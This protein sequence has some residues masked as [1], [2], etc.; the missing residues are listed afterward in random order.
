MK[1]KKHTVLLTKISCL[2]TIIIATVLL[3]IFYGLSWQGIDRI[4]GTITD[5]DTSS[6]ED[7]DDF[8]QKKDNHAIFHYNYTYKN[9][10][11]T[12]EYEI[13]ETNGGYKLHLKKHDIGSDV[14]I[15]LKPEN[16]SESNI[17]KEYFTN[18]YCLGFGIV[19]SLG[20]LLLLLYFT[21]AFKEVTT[22]LKEMFA[23]E[24]SNSVGTGMDKII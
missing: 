24:V 11:Y 18:K 9:N 19:F 21:C 10:T 17:D 3:W 12:G 14:G 22:E 20:L 4:V 6:I 2:V 23:E 7:C 5:I 15:Y 13:C 8:D 16:P 1:C